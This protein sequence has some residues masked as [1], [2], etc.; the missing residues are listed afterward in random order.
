MGDGVQRQERGPPRWSTARFGHRHF[1]KKA[2]RL[3]A[4]VPSPTPRRGRVRRF[5]QHRDAALES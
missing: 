2:P 1:D 3:F 4:A 5:Y